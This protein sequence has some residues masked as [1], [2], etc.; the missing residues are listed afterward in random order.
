MSELALVLEIRLVTGRFHGLGDWPPSPF[1]LFSALVAGAFAGQWGAEDPAPKQAVFRWLERL[2][3]PTIAAPASTVA[4]PTTIYVPNNDLDAVDGDPDR[5]AEIRGSTKT[6]RPR[7]FDPDVPFLYVWR[8]AGDPAPAA[9]LLGLAE[10]L[11]TFGR[12]IDPAFARGGILDAAEAERRLTDR[13]GPVFRPGGAGVSSLPCPRA[14]SFDQLAARHAAT[15][16]RFEVRADGRSRRTVFTQAPRPT[17]MLVPYDAPDRILLY[18][19]VR[20]TGERV[21]RD[22]R[23]ALRLAETVR[24]RLAERLIATMPDREAEIRRIV[25]GEGAG[26]A[27]KRRRLAFLPLPSI[28]HVQSDF[29]I[30]RIA[31]RVPA[32]CPL[33]P[34]D[35]RW[36]L[37]GLDLGAVDPETGEVPDDD[38]PILVEAEER[39]MLGHYAGAPSRRWRSV[40]PVALPR[41]P[42]RGGGGAE[43]LR[44]EADAAKAL[45]QALRHAGLDS[46]AAA[47]RI[48]R[49]PF[50][51]NGTRAD[52]LDAG[53]FDPGRLVH[54]ELE[55]P[56]PIGGPVVVGDG[57]FLGLGLFRPVR[58]AP[59]IVAFALAEPVAEAA[60]PA[61]V[62][63]FRRALMARV[64]SHLGER[65][66][67]P[68]FF[69]GHEADGSPSTAEP[70]AHVFLAFDPGPAPRLLAIA[71]HRVD[72]R[73][74]GRDLPYERECRQLDEALA[75]L[76]DLRAGP[77]GRFALS[78]LRE[79]GDG[80]PLIGPFRSFVSATPYRPCRHPGR[81]ADPAAFVAADAAAA[82]RSFG[83]PAPVVTVLDLARGRRGGL[84][85]RLRLDF[86]VAVEGPILLGRDA[87]RGSGLFRGVEGR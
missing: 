65:D 59:A 31:V 9:D 52:G 23:T 21:V 5:I 81:H 37:S 76:V 18:D 56:R 86:A 1:R 32:E 43:R 4:R 44:S 35:L 25:R 73:P 19:L 39:G 6:F 67:L 47:V 62:A 70:H 66:A 77:V 46:T 17:P 61:L 27:D 69:S 40:T 12:G 7:L 38:G 48:Q 55:L 75:D 22:G 41:T 57:R 20:P 3:P 51:G 83:L 33:H 85:A 74:R 13:G 26:D 8:L 15:L 53:R 16:K 24:D 45:L 11:H 79:P 2:P 58:T 64:G 29:G 87:H 14:G 72:R 60:G 71:P 49:E 30:R 54:A 28:G 34:D 36:G 42:H 80:D 82:C 10:R 84:A 78:P 68:V 50:D 63:A